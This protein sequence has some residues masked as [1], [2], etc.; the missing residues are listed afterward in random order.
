[1]K[2]PL[3]GNQPVYQQMTNTVPYYPVYPPTG[4]PYPPAGYPMYPPMGMT[5]GYPYGMYNMQG[6]PGMP[7]MTGMPQGYP[8]QNQYQPSFTHPLHP[9]MNPTNQPQMLYNDPK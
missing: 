5:P 4:Y 2:K 8:I 1:V 7:Q 3:E 9:H 6:I